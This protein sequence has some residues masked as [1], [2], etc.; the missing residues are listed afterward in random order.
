MHAVIKIK[1]PSILGGERPITWEESAALCLISLQHAM[2]HT[3]DETAYNRSNGVYNLVWDTLYRC[4][5]L[6]PGYMDQLLTWAISH[7]D[8]VTVKE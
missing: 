4:T 3:D 5:R 6:H 2:R 8:Q 7:Q 1:S